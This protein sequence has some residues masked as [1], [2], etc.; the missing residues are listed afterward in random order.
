MQKVEGSNPFSRFQKACI[1]RSFSWAQV[2]SSI[3]RRARFQSGLGRE[4]GPARQIFETTHWSLLGVRPR[5]Y[6]RRHPDSGIR[7]AADSRSRPRVNRAN[8]EL[9]EAQPPRERGES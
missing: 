2:M 9:A 4:R 5:G 3:L 6:R 7:E 1:C 8:L